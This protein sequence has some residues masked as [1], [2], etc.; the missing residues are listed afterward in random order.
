MQTFNLG[1]LFVSTVAATQ[2]CEMKVKTIEI[3]TLQLLQFYERE[4]NTSENVKSNKLKV[5]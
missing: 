1:K 5:M 2:Y 4:M 3:K